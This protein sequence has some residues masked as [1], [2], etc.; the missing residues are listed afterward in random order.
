MYTMYTYSYLIQ[1]DIIYLD[2]L[3]YKSQ[4]F[5]DSMKLR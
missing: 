5:Q 1:H 3:P 4:K 2:A